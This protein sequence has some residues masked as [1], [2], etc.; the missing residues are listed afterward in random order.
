MNPLFRDPKEFLIF[1]VNTKA[2]TTTQSRKLVFFHAVVLEPRNP[3]ND[4]SLLPTWGEVLL[5]DY[6]YRLR[7]K[8]ILKRQ[9][10][11][12]DFNS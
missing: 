3:V 9:K 2:E 7:L 4:W 6:S 1:G 11:K 5:L 12:A 8:K 10:G